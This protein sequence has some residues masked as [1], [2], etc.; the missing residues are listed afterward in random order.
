MLP[1]ISIV[2]PSYNQGP[3]LEECLR[4]I[5][6]QDYPNLEHFVIDGASSDDSANI[7]RMHA[8]NL[9]WW[10]SEPDCGQTDALRKGFQRATGDLLNWINSDDALCPGALQIVGNLFEK[11]PGSVIAGN[12]LLYDEETGASRVLVQRNLT[13]SDMISIWTNRSFYSQPGVFFPRSMYE[14]VGGLDITLHYCMDHDLMVRLLKSCPVV[15]TEAVLAK[16]RQHPRSKTCSQ[17]GAMIVEG[18]RVSR[19]YWCDLPADERGTA[20]M[21]MYSHLIRLMVGRL[22]HRAPREAGVIAQEILRRLRAPKKSGSELL[23]SGS[24]AHRAGERERRRA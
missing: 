2:T 7:I 8:P 6:S 21:R 11:H 5:D 3:F 23:T 1:K 4:S 9:T 24:D 19:R 20:S 10:T 16:A 17:L 14:E 22:Y 12:V 15:Y 13:M 18:T